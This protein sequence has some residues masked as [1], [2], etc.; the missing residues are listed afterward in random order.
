MKTQCDSDDFYR[1]S[2]RGEIESFPS[3][4]VSCIPS[5]DS[6]RFKFLFPFPL[7]THLGLRTGDHQENRFMLPPLIPWSISSGLLGRLAKKGQA[8]FFC[9]DSRVSHFYFSDINT[10]FV[11]YCNQSATLDSNSSIT[12]SI[13]SPGMGYKRA[14]QHWINHG[15]QQRHFL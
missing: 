6:C 12:F 11:S 10:T 9:E 2:P 5:G 14:R 15:R 8:I 1:I 3:F 4:L 13:H 7:Y